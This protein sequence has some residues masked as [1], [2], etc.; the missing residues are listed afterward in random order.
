[1]TSTA[2]KWCPN[3]C[4]KTVT[5]TFERKPAKHYECSECEKR[6][7]KKQLDDY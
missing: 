3:G 4:G 7:T 2:Y 5:Y 1:M 6:F